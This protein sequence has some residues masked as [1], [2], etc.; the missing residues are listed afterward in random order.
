[1]IEAIYSQ[2]LKSKK[3]TFNNVII[4]K[5]TD[6]SSQT[7]PYSVL[8]ARYSLNNLQANYMPVNKEVSFCG[9]KS[10][11]TSKPKVQPKADK[12]KPEITPK[13]K[14]KAGKKVKSYSEC[15]KLYGFDAGVVDVTKLP[16]SELIIGDFYPELSEDIAILTKAETHAVL[17]MEEGVNPKTFVHSFANHMASLGTS[18]KTR[19]LYID[20]PEEAKTELMKRN[21]A[22]KMI[23][24]GQK[25]E[26]GKTLEIPIPQASII[27]VLEDVSE[28]IPQEK[29]VFINDFSEAFKDVPEEEFSNLRDFLQKKFPDISI[30]GIANKVS[31]Y[32][33]KD[34]LFD[35]PE[36]NEA[37][38]MQF[39]DEI[40]DV[41]VAK[42]ELKGLS[43]QATKELQKLNPELVESVLESYKKPPL[44]ITPEALNLLIDKTAAV[45][46]EALPHSA[47][48]MLNLVAAAKTSEKS[49]LHL[50]GPVDITEADVKQFFIN[51]AKLVDLFR[52]KADQFNL[53]ENVTTKLSD[54]GGNHTVKEA[55]QDDLIAFLKNPK[56]FI[57]ER[58]TA[59]KG[60]LL[61]GPTGNGKTLLARAI[62]G[63]SNTPFIAVSGSEFIEKYVGMGAKRVREFC[64]NLRKAAE[65][66][67]NKTAIGFIDEFDAL[68]RKR[69]G[70]EGGEEAAQTLNQLLIEMD[71]FNNKE[72][73]IKVIFMAATNRKDI[74]DPAVIRRF[75]DSFTINNPQTNA[76]R[77]EILDI[78]T[79]NLNFASEEEKAKILTET[80]KLTD[81]MSGDSIAKVVKKAL[82][83]VSKRDVNKFI[84]NDDMVEGYLQVLAGPVDKTTSEMPLKEIQ[85]TV[86]H[87][88]GHAFIIDLLKPLLGDKI[89][90]I[91]LEPRGHFL[92]AVFH[93]PEFKVTP[94]FKSVILSGAVK[95]AGGMSEPEYNH[96]GN[97]AGVSSDVENATELF[98][99]AIKKWGLG[100]FTP[101]IA[102]SP[103]LAVIYKDENKKDLELMSNTSRK[104]SQI[105]LDFGND[106]LDEYMKMFEVNVGK[107]GNSLSGEAFSKMRQEWLA[108][109]GKIEAEKKLL[110]E[111]STIVD[112]AFN[113]NKGIVNKATQMVHEA[114]HTNGLAKKLL[115]RATNAAKRFV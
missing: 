23:K 51:N 28:T 33:D 115:Q 4:P 24:N 113:S 82:K 47:F 61:E 20:D 83:L 15:L 97:S 18:P 91:T 94:D 85:N 16:K 78:H 68:G 19:I 58:K 81:D 44:K 90:F 69:S 64:A 54:V 26:L 9:T 42:L 1:M 96:I 14:S 88:A 40:L 55:I 73:K 52:G 66:A 114:L 36:I 57:E 46:K 12:K 79:K 98:E 101:P 34:E 6:K 21:L 70:E 99:K 62:A 71:G 106:F 25:P 35:I 11:E 103:E 17:E 95:Y 105:G 93:H 72:S 84:T 67:P 77:R 59:P 45:S 60:F 48:K 104:I 49:G 13:K 7:I 92:G 5:N 53:A 100:R 75:A 111:V 43:A 63:E 80:A 31:L 56:K 76:E 74:L 50:K 39:K 2:N 27:D 89:S 10:K 86:R 32:S 30:V 107:G 3:S 109:T 29:I 37:P 38:T 41:N 87:E 8:P 108:R 112:K 22:E 102:I 65:N 110:S